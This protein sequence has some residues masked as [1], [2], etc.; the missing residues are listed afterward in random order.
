MDRDDLSIYFRDH[1]DFGV[2]WSEAATNEL[3]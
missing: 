1:R 2:M 3:I